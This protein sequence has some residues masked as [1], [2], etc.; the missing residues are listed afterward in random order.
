LHFWTGQYPITLCG[1]FGVKIGSII[2]IL[3]DKAMVIKMAMVAIL[4][5]IAS[6]DGYHFEKDINCL[7]PF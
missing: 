6:S 1:I 4:I 2:A 5:I 7:Y 3:S